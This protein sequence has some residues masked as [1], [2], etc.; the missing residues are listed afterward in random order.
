MTYHKCE[1]N[2]VLNVWRAPD[3]II[4]DLANAV[5]KTDGLLTATTGFGCQ[6]ASKN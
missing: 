3:A 6:S 4:L 1:E 2:D 5:E